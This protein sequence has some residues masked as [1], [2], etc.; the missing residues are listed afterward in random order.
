MSGTKPQDV[1]FE[2]RFREHLKDWPAQSWP[3]MPSRPAPPSRSALSQVRLLVILGLV[4]LGVFLYWFFQPERTGGGL[5]YG[6]FV[7]GLI[8]RAA[9][10]LFEWLYYARPKLEPF[11]PQIGRAHV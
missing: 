9:C 3:E 11:V 1:D 10:W 4:S 5:L 7:A 2:T 8:Y 6:L